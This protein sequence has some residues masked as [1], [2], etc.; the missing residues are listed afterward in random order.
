MRVACARKHISD[1]PPV[2]ICRT[3][4]TKRNMRVL[5]KVMLFIKRCYIV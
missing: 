5:A 3:M 4:W 2:N 1:T